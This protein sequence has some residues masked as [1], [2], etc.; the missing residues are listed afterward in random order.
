MDSIQRK[1]ERTN[2]L[3]ICVEY[4]RENN[5]QSFFFFYHSFVGNMDTAI[6]SNYA[7]VVRELFKTEF[8]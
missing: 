1:S 3:K 8:N 6:N 4:I 7:P 5:K 2:S